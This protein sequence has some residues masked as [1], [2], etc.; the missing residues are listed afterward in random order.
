MSRTPLGAYHGRLLLMGR[1]NDAAADHH[2]AIRAIRSGVTQVALDRD[3]GRWRGLAFAI[4]DLARLVSGQCTASAFCDARP[5][6]G[7]LA[8]RLVDAIDDQIDPPAWRVVN[9]EVRLQIG[10]E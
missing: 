5:A 10:A 2:E 8:E 9:A 4:A 3:I 7:A 1:A 6:I